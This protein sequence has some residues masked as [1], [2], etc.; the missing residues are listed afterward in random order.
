MKAEQLLYSRLCFA[1]TCTTIK[2]DADERRA[3]IVNNLA[4][5]MDQHSRPVFT[6]VTW[7]EL[8]KWLR[9]T[10]K[11]Q[12]LLNFLEGTELGPHEAEIALRDL[13]MCEDFMKFNWLKWFARFG[14]NLGLD[15]PPVLLSMEKA[16]YEYIC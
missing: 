15:I 11:G 14:L 5:L 13:L 7:E 1:L 8:E 9:H 2:R 16:C 12:Q 6:R 3:E 10:R 4:Y